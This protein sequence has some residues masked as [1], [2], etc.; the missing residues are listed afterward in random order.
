VAG[1]VEER[2]RAVGRRYAVIVRTAVVTGVS[3]VALLQAEPD[4]LPVLL[5]LVAALAAWSVVFVTLVSRRW[6]VPVDTAV[7]AALCLAQPWAVPV[8]AVANST[9]WVLAAVSSTAVAHQWYTSVRGGSVLTTALVLTYVAGA[10]LAAPEDWGYSVSIG[11]WTFVEAAMSRALFLLVRTGARVADRGAAESERVRR[12]SA[13]AEARRADEREHLA[14]LHDTAAATLLATGLGMVRGSEPWLACQAARDLEVLAARAHAAEG[15]A[16]LARLLGDVARHSVVHVDLRTPD[17]VRLP[18]PAA[19]AFSRAVHEA[20]SNVARHAG[21]DRA[22]VVVTHDSD[23]T[24]VEVTDTGRGFDPER[25]PA[26]RRGLSG[27]IVD[28]MVRA[29]GRATV[30]A[31]PGAGTRVCLVWPDE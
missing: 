9:N 4:R 19:V 24:T 26:H 17:V 28:R 2:L 29:G 23:V 6:V 15:R 27:S 11:L 12:E 18:A 25:I 7:I 13:V 31:R 14:A 30:T 16:D 8:E 3:V 10:G 21:V 1:A 20:L 22:S 5:A